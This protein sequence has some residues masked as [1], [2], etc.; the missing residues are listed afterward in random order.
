MAGRIVDSVYN[1]YPNGK[2]YTSLFYTYI[3]DSSVV[4]VSL[5]KDSTGTP[6]VTN[7]NGSAVFYD[8]DF[9]YVTGKGNIKNGKY[10]GEWTGELRSKDTLRYK[11][12]YA[13]GR[14][15]SGEST[16]GKG[17]MY[18]YSTSELKPQFKGGMTAFYRQIAKGVRYPPEA[19]RYRIQGIA[20]VRFVIKSNGEIS[21]VRV[22]NDV[23]PALAAEAVRMVKTSK[24]WSPGAIKGRV[25]DVSFTVPVS[26]TLG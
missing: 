4:N 13:E 12:V 3:G 6:L 15:L 19:V 2:L 10:D 18:H 16:D 8:E 25:V 26:F 9:K 22:I 1:F 5:V 23:H 14:M 7:G 17:K 24:G 21:D 11:E 20:Q